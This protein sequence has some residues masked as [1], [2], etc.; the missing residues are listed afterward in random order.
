MLKVKIPPS[1]STSANMAANDPINALIS[2]YS[3]ILP[4][5]MNITRL[6]ISMINTEEAVFHLPFFRLSMVV[7]SIIAAPMCI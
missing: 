6:I 1:L 4:N 3:P 5:E 2:S 7:Q